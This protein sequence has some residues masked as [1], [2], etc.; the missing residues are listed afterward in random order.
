MP[1]SHPQEIWFSNSDVPM[2]LICCCCCSVTQLSNSLRSHGLQH[3]RLPCLSLSPGVFSNSYPLNQWC[4]P[5]ISSS[6]IPFASY[7]QSFPVS[8]SFPMSQ[9]FQSGGQSIGAS[10]SILPKNIQDWFPLELF[11]LIS[12]LSKRLSRIFSS[13]LTQKHQFFGTQ[14]YL[15]SNSHPYM[16]TGKT[17]ALTRGTFVGK[18]MSLLFNMLSIGWS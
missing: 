16:T 14:P 15:W 8:G 10:A 9:L 18:V 13:T 17:I 7:L 12:L 2:N 5:T 6:V 4:H 11:G 3:D 1:E